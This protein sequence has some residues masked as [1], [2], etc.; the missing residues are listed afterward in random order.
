MGGEVVTDS[1]KKPT[2][3]RV[4]DSACRVMV[5]SAMI[6]ASTCVALIIAV[7]S[8]DTIGR[9]FF[10]R[11]FV[12]ALELTELFLAIVVILS[13]PYA[14]R[15]GLHIEIDIISQFFGSKAKQVSLGFSLLLTGAVFLMLTIQAYS[16]A[17]ESIATFE[18]SAGFLRV[19]IWLGKCAAAVGF[20]FAFFQTF[21]QF[22]ELLLT[23][24]VTKP[25]QVTDGV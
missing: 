4:V 1:L 20:L 24:K 2:V 21:S 8:F 22:L 13:I 3:L 11:P 16:N 17:A 6:V 10:S 7:N 14:Q 5:G 25:E 12:G 19:P 15:A 18:V 23:G 9:G